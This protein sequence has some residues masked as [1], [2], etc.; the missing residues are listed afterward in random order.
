MTKYRWVVLTLVAA[1][2]LTAILAVDRPRVA[3]DE[4]LDIFVKNPKGE[5]QTVASVHDLME[6]VNYNHKR[7][8]DALLKK[9][10]AKVTSPARLTAELANL[11]VLHGKPVEFREYA[12]SMKAAALELA[13]AA[14]SEDFQASQEA[15]GKLNNACSN[16]H[17]TYRIEDH[18]HDDDHDDHEGHDH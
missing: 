6:G 11:T 4:D 1:G 7:M 5:I 14:A 9:D 3:A 10:F 2:F 12:E 15:F 8:R 16:C 17:T 13:A 18:D